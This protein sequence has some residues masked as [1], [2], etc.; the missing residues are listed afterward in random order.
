MKP[1]EIL[2]A[3]FI[4]VL[5][6]A[7]GYMVYERLRGRLKAAGHSERFL[8][9]LFWLFFCHGG[10]LLVILTILFGEWSGMASLGGFFLILVAPI[11]LLP[12]TLHLWKKRFQD[13]PHQWAYRASLG[14]YVTIAG[15]FLFAFVFSRLVS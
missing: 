3:L 2:I 8:L 5:V 6:P 9:H 12:G 4:H 15:L 13:T 10:L 1:A 11:L 7:T 14:Y